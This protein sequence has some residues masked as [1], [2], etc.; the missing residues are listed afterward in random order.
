MKR[1]LSERLRKF[2]VRILHLVEVLR[3]INGARTIAGQLERSGPSIGHNYAEA[4]A[5]SS[6]AHFIS[7]IEIC[8]REAR[9]TQFALGVVID[10]KFVKP[11]RLRDLYQES[12]EIVAIMTT[13]GKRTKERASK[14]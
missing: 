3:K 8:E 12:S 9:E 10:K 6:V 5:A 14:K 1:D 11:R 2:A 4:Q 13:I 7:I